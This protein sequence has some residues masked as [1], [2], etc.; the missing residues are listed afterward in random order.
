MVQVQYKPLVWLWN[1]QFMALI[2]MR[3]HHL[4]CLA[5]LSDG[6]Y[7][8][9][10]LKCLRK[11]FLR[12]SGCWSWAIW[13]TYNHILFFFFF[14]LDPIRYISGS[15]TH[16]HFCCDRANCFKLWSCLSLIWHMETIW[17]YQN[18]VKS[19]YANDTYRPIKG[20]AKLSYMFVCQSLLVSPILNLTV[21]KVHMQSNELKFA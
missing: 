21:N 11:I 5:H 1:K 9:L 12:Y 2:I 10:K 3:N 7:I 16:I 4:A 6:F 13:L 15:K 14:K 19:Q 8:M 20:A 18:N 17:Y